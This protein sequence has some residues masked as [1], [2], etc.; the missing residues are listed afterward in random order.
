MVSGVFDKLQ[1]HEQV[2]DSS[3]SHGKVNQLVK[4]AISNAGYPNRAPACAAESM[5]STKSCR[6]AALHN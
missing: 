6:Y 3:E 2:V 1:P 4:Y 5:L